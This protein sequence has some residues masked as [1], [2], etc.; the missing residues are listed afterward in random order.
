MASAPTMR[1][2]TH[3]LRKQALRSAQP[4]FGCTQQPNEPWRE[5]AGA[6]P[7]QK[8]QPIAQLPF[9]SNGGIL[10]SGSGPRNPRTVN[11]AMTDEKTRGPNISMAT[12]PSTISRDEYGA[13]DW[14]VVGRCYPGGGATPDEQ[15]KPRRRPVSQA[16][17][18]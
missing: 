14:S 3:S 7:E 5:K 17:S 16:T 10:Y 1:P 15:S 13:G 4:I 2:P 8:I 11:V 12:E 9:S 18:D 6:K